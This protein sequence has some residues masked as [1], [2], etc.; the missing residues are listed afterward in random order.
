MRMSNHDRLRCADCAMWR[1]C[2]QEVGTVTRTIQKGESLFACAQTFQGLFMVLS[3]SFK[4]HVALEERDADMIL[5]FSLP[6]E[7]LGLDALGEGRHQM[8]VTALEHAEV[9][10]LGSVRDADK[11]PLLEQFSVQMVRER[12]QARHALRGN[13]VERLWWFLQD[14]SARYAGL[15]MSRHTLRLPMTQTEIANYLDLTHETVCRVMRRFRD[16]CMVMYEHNRLRLSQTV[17]SDGI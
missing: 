7:L 15:G 2:R 9:C 11:G 5:G 16:R 1:H 4:S 12:L 6:G 14:L 8:T 3:G 10:C 13:A 17:R